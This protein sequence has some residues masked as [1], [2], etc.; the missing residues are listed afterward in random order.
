MDRRHPV[1]SRVACLLVA[2][3]CTVPGVVPAEGGPLPLQGEDRSADLA[4]RWTRIAFEE[5]SAARA[6]TSENSGDLLVRM[7]SGGAAR[8]AREK[9][10]DERLKSADE[11]IKRF[12]RE[13]IQ[14][15]T[16]QEDGRVRLGEN[17]YAAAR[18]RVCPLY[19]FC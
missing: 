10:S 2:L 11:G 18:G 6:Y 4:A 1:R 16:K 7:I 13:M 9:T 17:S 3:S 14:A 12:S 5:F 8:A 19:P 15:G